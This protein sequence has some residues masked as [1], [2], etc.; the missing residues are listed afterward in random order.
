LHAGSVCMAGRMPL[1][2][3]QPGVLTRSSGCSAPGGRRGL[4]HLELSK[5]S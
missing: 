5:G 1:R 2:S 4:A 3:L